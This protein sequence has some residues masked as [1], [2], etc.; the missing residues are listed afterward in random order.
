MTKDELLAR[1]KDVPG[2]ALMFIHCDDV[3]CIFFEVREV[4]LTKTKPTTI[5]RCSDVTFHPPHD[6]PDVPAVVLEM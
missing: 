2:H 4:R 6:E 5:I 1:I 3:D